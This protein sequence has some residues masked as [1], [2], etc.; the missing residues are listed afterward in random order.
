MY[1]G[2][3][4]CMRQPQKT[5]VYAKGP[6]I[7]GG[8]SPA[9]ML[10]CSGKPCQLAGGVWELHMAMEPFTTFTDEEVLGDDPPSNW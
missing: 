8:E 2:Q 3:N 7:L 5:L 9:T 1:G 6:A 10:T 4:Y